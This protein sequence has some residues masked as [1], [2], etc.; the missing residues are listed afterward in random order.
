MAED[1]ERV[2]E[3][4][5]KTGNTEGGDGRENEAINSLCAGSSP[6]T[7]AGYGG[8]KP[9][10]WWAESKQQRYHRPYG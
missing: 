10:S 7:S 4:G 9:G 6:A 2:N 5:A 8:S 1:P 3:T